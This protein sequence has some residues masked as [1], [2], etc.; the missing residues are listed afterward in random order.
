[1]KQCLCC[2][3]KGL[4][5][6]LNNGLCR[7][8]YEELTSLEKAYET[9]LVDTVSSESNPIKLI[10]S[11]SMLMI[12]LRKFECITNT[13][14]A[15]DCERLLTTLNSNISPFLD[16]NLISKNPTD[17]IKSDKTID[18]TIT[19]KLNIVDPISTTIPTI[20]PDVFYD[21]PS[22]LE[23][24]S[25]SIIPV[26]PTDNSVV[27]S[28][29]YSDNSNLEPSQANLDQPV[30]TIAIEP[31][32]QPI[33]T[34]LYSDAEN[35][36]Q[37]LIST[38]LTIDELAYYTFLLKDTYLKQLRD[39]KI[40]EICDTNLENLITSNLNK[41]SLNI[42]CPVEDIYSYYNY[43]SFSIQTTGLKSCCNDIIEIC[44]HKVRYGQI[45]DTF[46]TLVNPQKSISLTVENN[47][48]ISNR[49]LINAPTTD[50]VLTDFLN[51]TEGLKLVA[52]NFNFNF[53]FINYHYEKIFHKNITTKSECTIKLYRIRYKHY[54]GIPP[55]Y[56]SI[57]DCCTDI[58]STDDID[59]INNIE[60]IAA[61]TALAT[62]KIYEIL[63]SRYK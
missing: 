58:L 4:F 62:Y 6:K 60:S 42:N 53:D 8:C 17:T 5:L 61:S 39:Y 41:I 55:K 16:E 31:V 40:Y 19:P 25:S 2:S 59:K 3:N 13:V 38:N 22:S 33:D 18:T 28:D 51:F 47:T 44:A 1:M 9:I 50:V 24:K 35:L 63:K 43:V 48:K 11:T 32:T 23:G 26:L 49:D 12:K 14:K 45:E 15:S 57:L 30:E 56:F 21:K 54:H 29:L 36:V 20:K 46:S 52:H 7:N 37:T 34:S 27:L 10:A